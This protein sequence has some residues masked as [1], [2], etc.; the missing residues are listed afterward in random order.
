MARRKDSLANVS[1]SLGLLLDDADASCTSPGPSHRPSLSCAV[2]RCSEGSGA[3]TDDD[4]WTV[5]PVCLPRR[6]PLQD[7]DGELPRGILR[8]EEN[9]VIPPRQLSAPSADKSPGVFGCAAPRA[10]PEL[11]VGRP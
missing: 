2:G 11:G 10:F 8:L 3:E 9:L 5:C 7:E 4:T 6:E 1:P